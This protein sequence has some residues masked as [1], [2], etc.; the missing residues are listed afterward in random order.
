MI[1]CFATQTRHLTSP[2]IV[3]RFDTLSRLATPRLGPATASGAGS[4]SSPGARPA[5]TR[6]RPPPPAPGDCLAPAPWPTGCP[7]RGEWVPGVRGMGDD[8]LRGGLAA[9][10]S[11]L[12]TTLL[13]WREARGRGGHAKDVMKVFPKVPTLRVLGLRAAKSR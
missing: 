6:A 3:A 9:V 10:C 4:S 1:S 7:S 2:T 5:T 12:A 13:P 11:K 8:M